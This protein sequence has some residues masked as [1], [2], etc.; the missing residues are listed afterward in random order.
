MIDVKQKIKESK[1][2]PELKALLIE[3]CLLQLESKYGLSKSG[4]FESITNLPN[5]FSNSIEKEIRTE[6]ENLI[7]NKKI[8]GVLPSYQFKILFVNIHIL[9]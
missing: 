5:L 8:S 3:D 4:E 7:E 9:M 2:I 1:I 6:L